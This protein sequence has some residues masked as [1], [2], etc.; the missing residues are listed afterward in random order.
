MKHRKKWCLVFLLAGIVLMMVPFSIAYLT[1]V[2]T[3][4]NRITIGQ[5]DVMIEEEFTPPK[6]WQPDAVYKKD[7]KVRNTGSVP[8]YIRV[9]AAL[10]DTAIPAHMDFDTKD[11]TQADD[12]YWYYA[13]IVEP[14]AVT[15]SLFTKVTIG[16]IEE[17]QRKTFDIILYAESVQ[18]EGYTSIQAAF[19]GIR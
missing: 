19:A 9:Y 11:W 8:C 7:V 12:G 18:A 2:E 16:D 6:Q 5:N 1:H 15:S 14:G 17:E 10:S 13:G 4:E 3:R